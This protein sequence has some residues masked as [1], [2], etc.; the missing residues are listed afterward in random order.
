MSMEADLARVVQRLILPE[1]IKVHFLVEIFGAL[2]WEFEGVDSGAHDSE[3]QEK[4]A[5]KKLLRSQRS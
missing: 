2:Q 3:A 5:A 1:S 4:K